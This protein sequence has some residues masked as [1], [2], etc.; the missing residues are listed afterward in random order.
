MD[1]QPSDPMDAYHA[2]RNGKLPHLEAQAIIAAATTGDP[3]YA[4]YYMAY[5]HDS[6]RVWAENVIARA[7]TGD[8]AD[9]A[10]KMV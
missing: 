4:A 8:P 2:C 7:T 6:D 3:A 5:Y 10:Y 9:V 1:N